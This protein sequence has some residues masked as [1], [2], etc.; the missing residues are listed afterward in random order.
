MKRMYKEVKCHIYGE[1][2]DPCE[3]CGYG[4]NIKKILMKKFNSKS[5]S[6]GKYM[7]LRDEF[8]EPLSQFCLKMPDS[9]TIVYFDTTYFRGDEKSDDSSSNKCKAEL[10]IDGPSENKVIGELEKTLFIN[11]DT[12]C[13][14]IDEKK[15]IV[16]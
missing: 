2:D 12:K 11:P 3:N 9:T 6:I 8:D 4:D 14:K 7:N 16:E 15:K 13:Y 10:V 1:V 5:I